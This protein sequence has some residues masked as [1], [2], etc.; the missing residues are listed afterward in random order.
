MRATASRVG[1]VAAALVVMLAARDGAAQTS[2]EARRVFAGS[3]LA[4]NIDN[5]VWSP[6]GSQ[7]SGEALAVGV[8]FG[9][10]FADRWSV[11]AEGEWPTSDQTVVNQYSYQSGY[12]YGS[13]TYTSM[14]RTTY[15]TP[16]VAVLFGVHWRLPKR[17]DIAFQFGPCFR[18]EQRSDEYQTTV[19]G[20]VTESRQYSSNDWQLRAS[21]GGEVAVGVT[22]RVA[23]VGQV[24]VHGA[25]DPW[26][27]SGRVVRPAV[28]VRVRF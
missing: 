2:A 16:T 25:L 3:S 20:T 10:N 19:N 4:W 12:P 8:A 26:G 14:T 23:V 7:R 1:T 21:V 24:R 15:R 22:S 11:Q 13:Q 18:K 28:G 27:E 6:S 5:S 9:M 17:V